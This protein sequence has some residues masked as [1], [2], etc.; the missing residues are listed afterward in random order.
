VLISFYINLPFGVCAAVAMAFAFQPPKAAAP[1]HVS[2]REKILQLDLPGMILICAA[3]VCFSLSMRWAG[4]EKPWGSSEVI[5]TLVGTV[6]LLASF[7]FEQ[8]YQGERAL[9]VPRFMKNRTLIV[10][11]VFELL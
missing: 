11:F 9:C 2:I 1:V 8:W 5:G 4:V 6:L 10:G 7:A 3:V